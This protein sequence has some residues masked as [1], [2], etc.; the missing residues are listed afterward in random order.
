M[1]IEYT[2]NLPQ[3]T[4]TAQQV[5]QN[6]AEAARL[7]GTTLSDLMQRA[8]HAV[9]RY[10]VDH[11]NSAERIV[12][13][14][15]KGNNAGDGYVIAQKCVEAGYDVCVYPVFPPSLLSGDAKSA[16]QAYRG[17]ISDNLGAVLQSQ[18]TVVV[19]AVF[20]SGFAGQLPEHIQDVFSIINGLRDVAKIA[21]DLPSGLNATTSQTTQHCFCADVTITF[22]GLKCGLLTGSAK[23]VVGKLYVADLKI[24][25]AFEQ[26]VNSTISFLAHDTLL[27][28]CPKREIDSYKNNHGHVLLIGGNLGMAGAIRL[29]AEAS[30]RSG[31]GLVSVATHP[32]NCQTVL[33][34]RYELMVHGVSGA[35]QL[36]PLLTRA[37]VIVIGPGLGTDNWANELL[38]SAIACGKP[39]VVDADGLNLLAKRRLPIANAVITPHVGEAKRLLSL[40]DPQVEID[41]RFLAVSLLHQY[42]Q[43]ICVLKGPGTI[44]SDGKRM[45]INRSGCSGMASAGM[46]D[47]LSGIIGSFMAQGLERFDAATLAVY[48]HGLAAEQAAHQGSK[49]MLASDLF[50]HIR[51]IVK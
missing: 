46:G 45:N 26:L 40:F 6:E 11:Y 29:A 10:I 13:L 15:G 49:G 36:Q 35:S 34:G 51:S 38:D 20:G 12:V 17:N 32:E 22:I 3:L 43:S 28:L 16:F 41:N 23:R 7:S 19:D 4:Y 31:A 47:V 2:D 44:I 48:I 42:Y 8:G 9:F 50:E 37:Q 21:V 39:L 30:L 5:Q 25:H 24:K 14:A 1:A 27:A 33:Q 18:P